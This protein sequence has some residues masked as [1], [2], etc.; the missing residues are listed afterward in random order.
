MIVEMQERP[1]TADTVDL[2]LDVR[3]SGRGSG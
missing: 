2:D 3:C 1:A